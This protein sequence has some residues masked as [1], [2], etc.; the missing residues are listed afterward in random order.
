[1]H[2]YMHAWCLQ[3]SEE[4]GPPPTGDTGSHEATCWESNRGHMEEQVLLTDAQS[5]QHQF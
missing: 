3:K 2:V 4:S 1:M 5:I